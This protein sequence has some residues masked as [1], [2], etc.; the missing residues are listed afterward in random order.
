M[1]PARDSNSHACMQ[2][3]RAPVNLLRRRKKCHFSRRALAQAV[4]A[5]CVWGEGGDALLADYDALVTANEFHSRYKHV[6]L[7]AISMRRNRGTLAQHGTNDHGQP[8]YR[9][10][11]LMALERDVRH[12]QQQRSASAA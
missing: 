4:G 6:S 2:V 9:Y 12:R 5:F 3:S 8:L 1:N 11:D 10:G 7:A